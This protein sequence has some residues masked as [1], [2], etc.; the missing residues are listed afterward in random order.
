M[1]VLGEGERYD[2]GVA[3]G[4]LEHKV[5]VLTAIVLSCYFRGVLKVENMIA[6][7][8]SRLNVYLIRF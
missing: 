4:D 5:V 7:T 2:G 6:R 8:K 1:P 3:N